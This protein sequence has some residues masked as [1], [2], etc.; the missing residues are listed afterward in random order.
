MLNPRR[1]LEDSILAATSALA[2]PAFATAAQERETTAASPNERLAVA[3]IGTGGRGQAHAHSFA[4]R[5]DCDV[6]AICDADLGRARGTA[7][8]V[9]KRQR[10]KVPAYQDLRKIIDD[11]QD[12]FERTREHLG[13]N[14]VD[15]E[16][17]RLTLGPWLQF[18]SDNERFVGNEPANAMLT[19]EYRRP[20]A[21]PT[22]D[23]V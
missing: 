4:G 2:G 17:T 1:F 10:R 9:A 23:D 15:I 5:S 19:R 16:K 8:A 13:R 18:D 7:D 20:F 22:E 11:A 12:R 21:V 6:V 3:V 14:G